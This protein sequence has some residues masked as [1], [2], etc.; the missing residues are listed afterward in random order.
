MN[1]TATRRLWPPTL[2][3]RMTSVVIVLVLAATVLVAMLALKIAE[4][5]MKAVIGDQQY[6]SISS[7]AAFIDDRLDAKK[8]LMTILAADL[9][10]AARTD[11]HQVQAYLK[12]HAD[13]RTEFLNLTAFASDGRLI[14]SLHPLP[15]GVPITGAGAQYFEAT[16]AHRKSIVSAPFISRLSDEPVV[17]VTAPLF[18]DAGKLLVVLAGT[19][20]LRD[21]DF[22]RQVDML[23]SG[24]SGYA[25]VMTTDG[26]LV[27]HPDKARLMRHI[28]HRPGTNKA[29]DMALAG[30]EGWTEA[31]NKDGVDGIYSYKRLKSADWILAARYPT[32][33]AFAPMARMR[34]QAVLAGA[35]VALLA[36]LVAWLL[37]HRMLAPLETLR[38]N[39][40]SIRRDGADIALLQGGTPDEIGELGSAFYDLMAEREQAL[41]R[42]RASEQRARI[43][44]D[45][46]PALISFVNRDQCYEFANAHYQDMLGVDPKSMIGQSVRATL[47]ERNYERIAANL[48]AAMRGEHM[49]F[50]AQFETRG[51]D[52]H[53]TFDYTPAL[54]DDTGSGGVYILVTDISERKT[55]ELI[56]AASE[57][58]LQLITD[59]LPVLISYIDP[60]HHFQF[61][62]ATF[63]KWF[64]LA[65]GSLV[66]RALADVFGDAVYQLTKPH[67]ETCF[68]GQTVAFEIKMAVAGSQRI[69][70]TTFIP[71]LQGDA[72]VAGVY[73]LTHDMTHVKEVEEK[74]IELARVD[75]LTGIANRRRFVEA[76]YQASE[77]ARRHGGAMA[78]AYLDIDHF[79]NINDTH[80]H[81]I[82]DAVL[83]EFAQRL[84]GNVRATDTVAR[85]SGDE[86]VIIFENLNSEQEVLPV[87]AKIAKAIRVPFDGAGVPL[88][89][90]ASIGIALF[91][92]AGQTHE[93]LLAS[94]DS[95]LYHAKRNGRDGI[96]M[97]GR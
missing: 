69:L 85:L 37:I 31:L 95:A 56:L 71:D 20:A 78:L 44:A 83:K 76:L 49:H 60:A 70:E 33:E 11:A 86:F 29:T 90:T 22:L 91:S 63:D 7:A 35:A 39:V 77:R 26:I 65:P 81:A 47:G 6:A 9:P 82:G 43:I 87:A 36:G 48:A 46:V 52:M 1:F 45:S 32:K 53:Y 34:Q 51:R 42:T 61:C 40:S 73:A 41:A 5:D 12:A 74:L 3:L 72:S 16:V 10:P 54:A 75:S 50:E 97:H 19:I 64:G 94:A 93:E 18:N 23:K 68:G 38:R 55:A 2:K 57:K 8:Q 15:S 4:R 21:R 88:A 27:A 28:H 96:A 66:G 79:K 17:L 84:L 14:A 62:N 89:V 13:L 80:G 59:N 58:R 30:Y 67:L 24:K 92:G 25:Y